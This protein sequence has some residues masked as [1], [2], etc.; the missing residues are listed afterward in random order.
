M[1]H[2]PVDPPNP[3]RTPVTITTS[4]WYRFRHTFSSDATSGRLLGNVS[5]HQI[6]HRQQDAEIGYRV[7]PWA[8]GRRR[9]T[10]RG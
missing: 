8:R 5:V 3:C 6:D 2:N 1:T 10:P 7:A 4:G 9:L